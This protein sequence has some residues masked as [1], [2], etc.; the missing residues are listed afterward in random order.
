MEC[1]SRK[2][3]IGHKN[4]SNQV[5]GAK[6]RTRIREQQEQQNNNNTTTQKR[7][8]DVDEKNR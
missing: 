7:Q 4:K 3:T 8:Q 5:Q 2:K 1:A 6:S